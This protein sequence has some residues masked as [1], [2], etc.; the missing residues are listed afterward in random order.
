[1]EIYL[2]LLLIRAEYLE[3][4]FISNNSLSNTPSLLVSVT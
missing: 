1:M 3:E 2:I 4:T